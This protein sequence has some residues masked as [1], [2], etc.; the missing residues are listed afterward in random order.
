MFEK[1]Y[2]IVHNGSNAKLIVTVNDDGIQTE[3]LDDTGKHIATGF[4]DLEVL[5]SQCY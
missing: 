3:I 2:E 5:T 1:E 4:M